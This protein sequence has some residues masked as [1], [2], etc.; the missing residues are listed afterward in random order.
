M[1][2]IG[3]LPWAVTMELHKEYT[4][5]YDWIVKEFTDLT[6]TFMASFLYCMD[7]D[8]IGEQTRSLYYQGISAFGGIS[9]T[10]RMALEKDSLVLIKDIRFKGKR[11][12]S[13]DD[14]KQYLEGYVGDY[15]EIEENAERIYIGSELPEEYTESESRKSL[16]GANAKAKANA[17]TA[18]PELIKIA[19]NPAFEENRKEKHNKNAK[20]GWYR[21]DVLFALP[22]YDENVLV[23]YNIFHARLLINHAENSRKYLYDILAIKKETSKP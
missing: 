3:R 8:T 17:T 18:V 14:V 12:I 22:V 5:R 15:Y 9:P 13:W 11:Q 6:F 20:Y 2:C 23:R 10:Y 1:V 19:S 4:E 7:Y 21:Y 16:M